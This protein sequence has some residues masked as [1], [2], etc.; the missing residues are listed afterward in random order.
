MIKIEVPTD[1]KAALKEVGKM[2]LAL[3]GVEK[4]VIIDT[5]TESTT[6]T[7]KQIK[8]G[9]CITGSAG[10]GGSGGSGGSDDQG[11]V[12]SELGDGPGIDPDC[13][14][15]SAPTFPD[16]VELDGEGIPWD[17]RIHSGGKTKYT[18]APFAW[19]KKRGVPGYVV[20]TVEQELRN[21]MAA[22][23]DNPV[24]PEPEPEASE[25]FAPP[26]PSG[27]APGETAPSGTAPGETAPSGT[28]PGGTAPGETAPSGTAPGETAPGETAPAPAPSPAAVTSDGPIISFAELNLAITAKGIDA[29]AVQAAVNKAGLQAYPLLAAR[30]D[31]VP[32]VAKELGL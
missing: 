26:P 23:P 2:F 14:S 22:S 28:A 27:T 15:A 19:K 17:A 9:V 24:V 5:R 16:G 29:A 13:I 12:T 11:E 4:T 32:I 7:E 10:S 20:T 18:K 31:L 21:A 8:L 3:S 30:A 6:L 25:A 1:D